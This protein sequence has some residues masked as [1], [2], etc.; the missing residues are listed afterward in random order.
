MVGADAEAPGGFRHHYSERILSF[1]KLPSSAGIRGDSQCKH[2]PR[3]LH[4][5]PHLNVFLL[6]QRKEPLVQEVGARHY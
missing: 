3:W 1:E 6:R 4:T 5:D 2:D